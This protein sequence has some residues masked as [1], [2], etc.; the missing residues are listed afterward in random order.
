LS[1]EHQKHQERHLRLA[2]DLRVCRTCVDVNA[3]VSA[4]FT[5]RVF[6][7]E[8]VQHVGGIEAC[9]VAQLPRDDLQRLRVRVDEQLRLAVD[10]ARVIPAARSVYTLV[11]LA[12]VPT[13]QG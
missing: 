6:L 10:R 4:L 11:S 8:L 12:V 13:D 5:G 7:A 9:V 3:V 1:A 2:T